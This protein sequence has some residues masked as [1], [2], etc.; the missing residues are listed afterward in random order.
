L[1]ILL[2]KVIIEKGQDCCQ[3]MLIHFNNVEIE[4][5]NK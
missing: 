3:M 2:E 5:A 1:L 4:I